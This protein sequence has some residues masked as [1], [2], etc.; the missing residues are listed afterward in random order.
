[1][2]RLC[3][4]VLLLCIF[5]GTLNLSKASTGSFIV[6]AGKELAYPIDVSS[7]DRIQLNFITTG[8]PNS[9]FHFSLAFPNSTILDL[10]EVDKYSISFTSDASGKCELIFNNTI[11]SQP[12]FIA[13]NYEVEH[14]ILGIPQMIFL[15][16]V[17]VVLAIVIMTGYVIMGK[18]SC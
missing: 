10:G 16:I 15:L 6:E 7:G 11:S 13:L 4:L 5:L 9:N 1:M 12:T 18:N 3:Y 8:D 17:I 14:Y 2:R